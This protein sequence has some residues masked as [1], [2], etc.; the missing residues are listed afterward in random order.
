MY[1][2]YENLITGSIYRTMPAT[3][4]TGEPYLQLERWNWDFQNWNG[5]IHN[6]LMT[7]ALL[8]E[9]KVIVEI[10]EEAVN[11]LKRSKISL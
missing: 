5:H 10:P 6:V 3:F 11:V 8:E 2:Y 4:N 7:R 1:K 9:G